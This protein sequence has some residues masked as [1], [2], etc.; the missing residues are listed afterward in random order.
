MKQA[1]TNMCMLRLLPPELKTKAN[2]IAIKENADNMPKGSNLSTLELASLTAK[3][4]HPGRIIKVHFMDGEAFVQ[5]K[6]DY[7]AKQWEKYA[8]IHF[9]FSR[10]S[11]AEIRISF[12]YMG[13]WSYLGTDCLLVP[14]NEPTINFGWFDMETP[15][16]EYSRTVIH[17]FG[18]ALGCPHEHSSPTADIPWDKEAVYNFY[19]APPN[20]WSKEEIDNNLFYK[21]TFS[22]ADATEFDPES[23]MVYPIPNSQTIGDFEVKGNTTLSETDK[24]YIGKIYPKES[25]KE[26]ELGA[27]VVVGTAASSH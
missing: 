2:E 14:K 22:E 6:V 10:D 15:D 4:W 17:E 25:N 11:N 21:Y 20:N 3:R 19:M 13:S 8:N 16:E 7:Y 5:K 23:I 18:H 27:K 24:Q 26:A 1:D 9:L 12:R